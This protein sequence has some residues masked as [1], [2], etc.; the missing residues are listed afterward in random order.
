[1]TV[2]DIPNAVVGLAASPLACEHLP[3][4]KKQFAAASPLQRAA[5]IGAHP[6]ARFAPY[7]GGLLRDAGSFRAA[8]QLCATGV[9]PIGQ[10]LNQKQ[11]EELLDAWE[12]NDQCLF[13]PAMPKNAGLLFEATRHLLPTSLP[14]WQKFVG[15]AQ[16]PSD[17]RRAAYYSYPDLRRLVEAELEDQEPF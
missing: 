13:A 15:A 11:L 9:L 7:A 8:E 10:Y 1:M 6:S 3:S 4:L 2:D 5:A 14:A 17:E 16:E 12:T